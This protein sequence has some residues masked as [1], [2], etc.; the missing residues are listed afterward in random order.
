MY[1]LISVVLYYVLIKI[2]GD[3]VFLHHFILVQLFGL[4]VHIYFI[5]KNKK[6]RV[7]IL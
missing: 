4:V 3:K 5:F 6:K 2:I 1:S 7:L